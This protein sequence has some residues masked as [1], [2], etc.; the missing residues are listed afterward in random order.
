MK[1]TILTLVQVPQL[2]EHFFGYFFIVKKDGN[3]LTY[4]EY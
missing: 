3:S 4:T 2:H 1:V